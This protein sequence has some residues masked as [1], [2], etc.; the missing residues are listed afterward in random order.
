MLNEV[1]FV[2]CVLRVSFSSQQTITIIK[3]KHTQGTRNILGSCPRGKRTC[4]LFY[5]VKRTLFFCILDSR[6]STVLLA[7]ANS[8]SKAS[9]LVVSLP[10]IRTKINNN[11]IIIYYYNYYS[12]IIMRL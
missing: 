10:F 5:F 2:F 9:H 1:F 3:Q 11:N 6:P 7:I 4:V 12:S 8:P